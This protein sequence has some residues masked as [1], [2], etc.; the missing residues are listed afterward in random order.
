MATSGSIDFTQTAGEMIKDALIL[1]GI[2]HEDETVNS[3]TEATALRFLNKMV[4]SYQV[5]GTHLWQVER[6]VVL[7]NNDVVAYTFDNKSGAGGDDG[8]VLE[9]G[10]VQT[11]FSAAEA[12][13]QTVLS[14]TSSTGMAASDKI[15]MELDSGSRD[16]TTIVSVDSSTQIT[17]TDALTGACASGNFIYTYTPTTDEIKYPEEIMNVRLRDED[18]TETPMIELSRHEY[19]EL[20]DKTTEG[21]P[22]TYYFDRQLANPVLR[23]YLEPTNLRTNVR[24]D[25]LKTLEDLDN[26]TNNLYFPDVWLE[27][28]TYQLA[29]RLAP[30]FG[31]EDK[32]GVLAPIGA[33]LLAA[34]KEHDTEDTIISLVPEIDP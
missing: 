25:Y 1:L 9:S 19:M 14:V 11:T 27:A 20:A 10:L 26:T 23:V 31:R 16:V 12:S 30:A 7:F 4:K 21:T 32:L 28:L 2:V 5:Q 18:G 22:Y 3:A 34:A 17:V 15:V 33:E 8:M 6:G 29:V 24:F 13:G